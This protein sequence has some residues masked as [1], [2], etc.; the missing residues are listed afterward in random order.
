M[1]TQLVTSASGRA[2]GVGDAKRQLR[3]STSTGTGSESTYIGYLIDAATRRIEGITNL[4]LLTQTWKAYPSQ[5]PS[6]R[7]YI[8]MPY[9]PLI[10]ITSST[11]IV[12]KDSS[13][14]TYLMAS[15]G[16]NSWRIDTVSKPGRLILENNADWPGETLYN[17]SPISIQF[18]CGYGTTKAGDAALIPEQLKLAVKQ[19]V[20]H[21]YENREA[22]IVGKAVTMI[23]ETV[24]ALI[25][26]YRV[27]NF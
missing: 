16:A 7:N 12:Y 5:W 10:H 17:I 14:S 15:T 1:H 24:D 21:W 6:T 25:G 2:V 18:I 20:G 3:M 19:L 9:S 23:P 13:G 8:E 27:Y 26:D 11:G 22:S 4:K